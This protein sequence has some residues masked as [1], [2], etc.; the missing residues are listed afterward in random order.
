M[1]GLLSP[2]AIVRDLH[3]HLL[4]EASG[5]GIHPAGVEENGTVDTPERNRLLSDRHNPFAI[6][7]CVFFELPQ[8]AHMSMN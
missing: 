3:H 5:P 8:V 6:S 2:A 7:T 1:N 4:L